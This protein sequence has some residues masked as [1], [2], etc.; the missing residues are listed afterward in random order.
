[1]E[2]GYLRDVLFRVVIFVREF[3]LDI[4]FLIVEFDCLNL[5]YAFEIHSLF[6]V[7]LRWHS[8]MREDLL[9]W[10]FVVLFRV[11]FSTLESKFVRHFNEFLR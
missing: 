8:A 2:E 6:D 11:D 10:I 9:L 3:L 7:Y 5:V 1:M 4:C